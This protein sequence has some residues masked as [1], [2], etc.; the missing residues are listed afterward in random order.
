MAERKQEGSRLRETFGKGRVT[1]VLWYSKL[2]TEKNIH[3]SSFF[4]VISKTLLKPA[5][6]VKKR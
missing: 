1:K 5:E 4:S 3:P 6:I 2:R